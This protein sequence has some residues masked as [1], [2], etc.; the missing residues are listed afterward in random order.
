MFSPM[1][2]ADS[3]NATFKKR[4]GPNR[5]YLLVLMATFFF[6][7]VPFM[8]EH[9]IS[10]SYVR[11]RYDWGVGE[12][13]NYSSIVSATGIVGQAILIPLLTMLKVNEVKFLLKFLNPKI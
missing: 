3:F 8:G 4:E 9:T 2:I 7:I 5:K 13:S 10:F 6:C 11:V 1:Q 12:Y